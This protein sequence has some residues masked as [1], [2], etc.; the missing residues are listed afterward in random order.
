MCFFHYELPEITFGNHEFVFGGEAG[1]SGLEVAGTGGVAPGGGEAC[2]E[3]SAPSD[4]EARRKAPAPG[5]GEVR[6]EALM[7]DGGEVGGEAPTPGRG[8]A[9]GEALPPGGGEV[10]GD[11]PAQDEATDGGGGRAGARVRWRRVRG[12]GVCGSGAGGSNSPSARHGA[13]D[14]LGPAAALARSPATAASGGR[15]LVGLG[16]GR[17]WTRRSI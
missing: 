8:E 6:G 4:G 5:G 7:P 2:G 11:A 10:R 3:S 1:A 14:S 16:L 9:H 17:S 15:K 12:S 13:A